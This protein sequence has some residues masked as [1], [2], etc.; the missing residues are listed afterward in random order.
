MHKKHANML[1]AVVVAACL[2]GGGGV[3]Y[4]LSNLLVQL[5][6]FAVLGYNGEA[7]W[8]FVAQGPR[9]LAALAIVTLII[10]LLQLVPLPPVL[11]MGLPG[12][13]L[14]VE[15]IRSVGEPAWRPLTV[16]SARTFVAFLGLIVPLTVLIMG[17]TVTTDIR[18]RIAM[19]VVVIGVASVLLGVVQV[20]GQNQEGVLYPENPLPGV[21]FGFFANRNSQ[22][23]F[24][25]ACLLLLVGC[26]AQQRLL[27]PRWILRFAVAVLLT[28]GVVLTQSRSGIAL[29]ALPLALFLLKAYVEGRRSNGQSGAM[30][31]PLQLAII[32]AVIAT[33][34]LGAVAAIPGSRLDAVKARFEQAGERRP[35]IWEDARFSA[36][37]FWPAGAGMGTFD[38]VYQVDESLEHISARRAGRA[39]NEYLE[40]VIE[41]GPFGLAVVLGWAIWILLAGWSALRDEQRRWPALAGSGI[42]LAAALQSALEFPLRNQTMLCVAAFAIVL[43]IPAGK[44]AQ[45][46][47]RDE[48]ASA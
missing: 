19:T 25:V 41:A 30:S 9:T 44:A 39:H 17:A 12:R 38:E 15:A 45:P 3:A 23:I 33:F 32:A 22:A 21:L 40:L 18:Q 5:T 28:T 14:V 20:M 13:E 46:P 42:L 16:S 4:G 1:L 2:F 29:L 8:R 36:E 43:L 11:W 26:F 34:T 31:R 48:G 6:A 37:R 24:L 35:E 10:P 47:L 27:S 7:A